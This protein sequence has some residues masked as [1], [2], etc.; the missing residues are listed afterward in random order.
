MN[1]SLVTAAGRVGIGIVVDSA[2]VPDSPQ[3]AACLVDGFEEVL[4]LGCTQDGQ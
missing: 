3:L 4:R 1:V 2:A